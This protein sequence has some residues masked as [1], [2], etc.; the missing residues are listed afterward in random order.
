MSIT[1]QQTHG[2]AGQLTVSCVSQ[3][4]PTQVPQTVTASQ[5]QASVSSVTQQQQVTHP[6]T[7]VIL[8]FMLLSKIRNL[9]Y[10]ILSLQ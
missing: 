7:Q 6:Q 3:S 9:K 1:A 8:K 10:I 2:Q 5:T 4:V